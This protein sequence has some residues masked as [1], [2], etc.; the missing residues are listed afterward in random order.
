M[1]LFK[2]IQL[3]KR[4]RTTQ[5]PMQ[6]TA[7]GGCQ[8]AC[9][10]PEHC[11]IMQV[12][13]Q[14]VADNQVRLQ[15]RD[16]AKVLLQKTNRQALILRTLTG[17]FQHALRDVDAVDPTFRAHRPGQLDQRVPGSEPDLQHVLAR[18]QRQ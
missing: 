2:P 7:T 16:L 3:L 18:L 14:T 15:A 17:Q 12:V 10:T 5:I 4:V 1:T 13:Q 8:A 11:W 6:N 9:C